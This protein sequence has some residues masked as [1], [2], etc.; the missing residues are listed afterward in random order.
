[1]TPELVWIIER[2]YALFQRYPQT[3]TPMTA[4][5]DEAPGAKEVERRVRRTRL[6]DQ[7]RDDLEVC[8]MGAFDGAS[9]K[10]FLPRLLEL[11]AEEASPWPSY[12][13]FKLGWSGARAWSSEER[14]VVMLF[15]GAR[16]LAQLRAG[17][18]RAV[19]DTFFDLAHAVGDLRP[20][21]LVWEWETTRTATVM[22][23][24]FVQEESSGLERR[25]RCDD[26]AP[27]HPLDAVTDEL[28]AWLR[29]PAV[30]ARLDQAYRAAPEAP[31][32]SLIAAAVVDLLRA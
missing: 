4:L 17:D 30:L 8:M 19:A 3:L 14:D 9:L 25:L 26:W 6:G 1:M 12:L 24:R 13:A 23:A 27:S 15:F 2:A 29:S 5:W 28:M 7:R 32:S 16:F 21:F 31:G 11:F 18:L 20:L 10:H 22:L